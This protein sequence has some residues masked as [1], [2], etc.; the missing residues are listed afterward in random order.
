MHGM[1][2]MQMALSAFARCSIACKSAFGGDRGRYEVLFLFSCWRIN[3]DIH[4]EILFMQTLF[5]TC[6][7]WSAFCLQYVGLIFLVQI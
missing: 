5:G 4:E 6:A 1:Y 3:M 7:L 2:H